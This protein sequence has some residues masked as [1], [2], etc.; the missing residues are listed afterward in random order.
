KSGRQNATPMEARAAHAAY[1]ARTGRI[2]LTCSTQSP[3][4]VRTAIAE[5]LGM[6]EADLRVVAPDVGGG[7]GQK[8]ILPPEYAVLVHICRMRRQSMSWIEDR[9]E[10]LMNGFHARDMRVK[11]KGAFDASG[12]LIAI[13][14]EIASNVGAYSGYP[15]SCAV[16]ALMAMAELPG[17]YDV[18]QY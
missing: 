1:D 16:E 4:I 3:H 17:P 14:A 2:T 9:R 6:P 11:L 18:Q 8:T 10:N 7:F 12:K 5:L 13:E 15:I